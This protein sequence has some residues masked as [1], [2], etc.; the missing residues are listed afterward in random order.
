MGTET[1]LNMRVEYTLTN[2][3]TYLIVKIDINVFT[4]GIAFGE[5]CSTV[6]HEVER[7]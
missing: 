3:S 4:E 5:S 1:H 7:L 6:L 2:T